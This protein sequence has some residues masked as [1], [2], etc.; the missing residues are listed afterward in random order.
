MSKFAR[1]S[2]GEALT[3]RR[4]KEL[5]SYDPDT[6]IFTWLIS[7]RR[8]LFGSKAGHIES[9]GYIRIGI[10]GK[11]YQAHRLA[12]LY[13][14]GHFPE[15]ELDHID[16]N[17]SNNKIENLR[18]ANRRNNAANR[19]VMSN[20]RLGV[21]GVYFAGEGRAKP[22]RAV[23]TVNKAPK[24]LGYFA[25]AEEASA[26]HLAEAQRHFGRFARG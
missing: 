13:Q 7:G 16:L 24:K 8:I 3:Q 1:Y 2:T 5:L 26:A 14:F 12:W 23:I 17:G 20:N 11:R 18:E 15:Y 19:A 4:L 21:K 10:E 6:G 9:N 22:Y 25:T